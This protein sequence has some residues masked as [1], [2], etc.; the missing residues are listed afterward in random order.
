MSDPISAYLENKPKHIEAEQSILG[1]MLLGEEAIVIAADLVSPEMFYLQKHQEIFTA[2]IGDYRQNGKCDLMTIGE[3]LRLSGRLQAVGGISYLTE[4]LNSVCTTSNVRMHARIMRDKYLLRRI[5]DLGIETVERTAKQGDPRDLL[6]EIESALI[7][8]ASQTKEGKKPDIGSILVNIQK[9]WDEAESGDIERILTPKDLFN[10]EGRPN[11]IPFYHPG[12][13]WMIAAPSSHGKTTFTIHLLVDVL[14]KGASVM[15]FSLEDSQEE[16][17][18]LLIANLADI[19]RIKLIS[20]VF[21]P[22]EKEAIQRAKNKLSGYPIS[23]YDKVRTVEEI[24]LKIKKEK[25]V[26]E[27]DIVVIDFIQ[28][29]KGDS[30]IYRRMTAAV[31]QLPDIADDLGVTI[32]CLS[33]MTEE[34]K[35]KG[36]GELFEAAD[37]VLVGKLPFPDNSDGR[38]NFF[39]LSIDKN[40]AFGP[41]G[42]CPELQFSKNW[43]RI[44]KR[45]AYGH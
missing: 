9:K 40:R 26:S 35:L 44:E 19:S 14:E 1:A 42:R 24:R 32:L 11:P 16:K 21:R 8:V 2:I 12:H 41:T 23:I 25:M 7:G 20:G 36:A 38:E 6:A 30:D 34:T 39:D 15:V 43:T 37:I 28:R 33:Q 27:V 3:Y 5:G 10:R 4:V 45:G 31:D 22:D 13:V 18:M 17:G 29:I